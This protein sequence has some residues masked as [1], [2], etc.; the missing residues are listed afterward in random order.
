MTNNNA[1]K[2]PGFLEELIRPVIGLTLGLGIMYAAA[3]GCLKIGDEL[4]LIKKRLPSEIPTYQ[5]CGDCNMRYQEFMEAVRRAYAKGTLSR[6]LPDLE[7]GIN[8]Y[9][10]DGHPFREF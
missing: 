8:K 9:H 2:G 6:P 5:K 3:Y 7:Q 4:G 10:A 1:T